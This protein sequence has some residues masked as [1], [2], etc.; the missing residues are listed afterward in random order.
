MSNKN[1]NR[2]CMSIRIIRIRVEGRRPAKY[3]VAVKAVCDL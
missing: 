3:V 1:Y 2:L